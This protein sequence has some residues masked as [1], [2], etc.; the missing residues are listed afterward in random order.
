MT[1]NYWIIG[2]ITKCVIALTTECTVVSVKKTRWLN[3][4]TLFFV[5]WSCFGFRMEGKDDVCRWRAGSK[6]P[7]RNTR[8]YLLQQQTVRPEREV[9]R[10]RKGEETII[11]HFLYANQRGGCWICAKGSLPQWDLPALSDVIFTTLFGNSSSK[12]GCGTSAQVWLKQSNL[13]P[14]MV[15]S[16]A[17]YKDEMQQV[18]RTA[19]NTRSSQHLIL[20]DLGSKYFYPQLPDQGTE[21]GYFLYLLF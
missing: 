19:R 15:P 2:L 4:L 1:P 12:G 14:G 9:G 21:T 8:L 7:K 18:D 6:T 17:S 13:Y 3:I 5:S 20:T 16:R 11:E 10:G